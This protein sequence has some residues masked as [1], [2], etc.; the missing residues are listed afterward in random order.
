M[1]AVT[2]PNALPDLENIR[3]D[4]LADVTTTFSAD[5]DALAAALRTAHDLAA[6]TAHSRVRVEPHTAATCSRL[7]LR[8]RD[9]AKPSAMSWGGGGDSRTVAA[10]LFRAEA[11]VPSPL[12]PPGC[13]GPSVESTPGGSP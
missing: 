7:A 6:T 12:R 4:V 8:R 3:E 2:G 5:R 1:S 11:A 10:T 13:A 9:L